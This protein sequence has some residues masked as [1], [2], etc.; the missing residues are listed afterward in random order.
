MLE[1]KDEEAPA[2]SA[3]SGFDIGPYGCPKCKTLVTMFIIGYIFGL[4]TAPYVLPVLYSIV[5]FNL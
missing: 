2:S 3:L 5:F 4:S 1:T